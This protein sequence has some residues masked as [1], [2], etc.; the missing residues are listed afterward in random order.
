MPFNTT[1][2]YDKRFAKDV[3][4][5]GLQDGLVPAIKSFSG[6][7]Y[8]GKHMCLGR[9]TERMKLIGLF[10]GGEE[11]SAHSRVPAGGTAPLREPELVGLQW[12][13]IHSRRLGGCVPISNT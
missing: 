13:R 3:R 1:K 10:F 9:L 5:L 8:I 11:L 12:E 2:S 4:R 7:L 6:S